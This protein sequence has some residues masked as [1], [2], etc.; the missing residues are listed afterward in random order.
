MT[1]EAGLTRRRLL[2]G[3]AGLM[4]LASGGCRRPATGSPTQLVPRLAAT[5]PPL[6]AWPWGRDELGNPVTTLERVSS[7]GHY[8]EFTDARFGLDQ[9]TAHY[10]PEPLRLEVGGLVRH[11]CV[12]DA[13]RLARFGVEERVYRLRCIE[14]WAMVIPWRGFPLR[15]LLAEVEPLSTARFVR[16]VAGVPST[17]RLA[18]P[19][20]S[21]AMTAEQAAS[22]MLAEG[23]GP[24]VWP[25]EEGLRLDE[26]MHDLTFLAT[27]MYGQD[28]TVANGAPLRLVVPWKYAF[29]SIKGL[30]RIELV[31][32]QPETFFHRLLPQEYGFYANVNPNVP[33][34]RWAQDREARYRGACPEPIVPTLMFNGY[35]EEVGH[36]YAGMDLAANF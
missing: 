16:F 24:V 22:G 8:W 3:A 33:H 25:Y 2:Q 14:A 27:G 9:A 21:P 23:M 28:L 11:P 29:K 34:P 12:Y 1:P 7:Y 10:V 15:R 4:V 26:A 35:E 5:L 31:A 32:D 13:A 17:R 36:L 30:K 18:R 19:T 20:S 6:P